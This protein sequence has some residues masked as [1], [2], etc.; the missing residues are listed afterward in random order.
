[1]EDPQLPPRQLYEIRGDPADSLDEYKRLW[2]EGTESSPPKSGP[3]RRGKQ[4]KQT[5]KTELTTPPV[6]PSVRQAREYN[7]AVLSFLSSCDSPRNI[8][9]EE[10]VFPPEPEFAY[11][12]GDDNDASASAE[13]ANTTL[14]AAHNSA[15]SLL[16]RKRPR[17]A[18]ASLAGLFVEAAFGTNASAVRGDDASEEEGTSTLLCRCAF[19]LMDCLMSSSL[20]DAGGLSSVA[21][22]VP[23]VAARSAEAAGAIFDDDDDVDG[24]DATKPGYARLTVTVDFLL[25]WVERFLEAIKADS[26]SSTAGPFPAGIHESSVGASPSELQFRFHLYKSRALSLRQPGG[27]PSPSAMKHDVKVRVARKE[28]KNVMEIYQ[29][30]LNR[31]P[32]EDL[33]GGGGAGAATVTTSK[34]EVSVAAGSVGS[35]LSDGGL[36]SSSTHAA[37]SGGKSNPH[38]ASAAVGVAATA[39]DPPPR[40]VAARLEAQNQCALS[41]KANFE[42]LKGN[43]RKALKLCAE[44]KLA[45]ERRR[46]SDGAGASGDAAVTAP[47]ASAAVATG[48]SATGSAVDMAMHHN[49][50]AL[51]HHASG[52]YHAALRY[53]AMALSCVEN[54]PSSGGASFASV[55]SAFERDGTF[56]HVPTAEILHNAA[57]CAFAA[58]NFTCAYECMARCV[59]SSPETYGGRARC[60]FRMAEGCIGIHAD[61]RRKRRREDGM[62][63]NSGLALRRDP[64]TDG[65]IINVSSAEHSRSAAAPAAELAPILGSPE[66]IVQVSADPLP[67]ALFCLQ[68]ALRLCESIPGSNRAVPDNS[69][70]REAAAVSL[71]FVYLELNDPMAA[72][73]MAGRVLNGNP[74]NS[75]DAVPGDAMFLRRRA[76]ARLYSCEALCMLNEPRRALC[77][78]VGDDHATEPA[79]A[80]GA[81]LPIVTAEAAEVLARQL[82]MLT[83]SERGESKAPKSS[84]GRGRLEDARS[85]ISVTSSG[86]AVLVGD[87]RTARDHAVRAIGER[88][89]LDASGSATA[90]YSGGAEAASNG[91]QARR[92]LLYCFLR[93]GDCEGAVKLLR[94]GR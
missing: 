93:E 5:P 3:K 1:M 78:L 61:L 36:P 13:Q 43:P 15:L 52:R 65:V 76:T 25:S 21:A 84:W 92:A 9:R 47:S 64:S 53:Y 40:W 8:D 69:N 66:D 59:G 26:A 28:L 73:S 33:R 17:E 38:P 16:A 71:A 22:S 60:W 86:C 48:T 23:S 19:L 24:A 91:A 20:G 67:R 49:N 82:A 11:L 7:C 30:K 34:D 94:A 29:H 88:G 18:A 85:A 63:D 6:E 51:I 2:D 74:G 81:A 10:S 50:L 89:G 68:R 14:A 56:L 87:L 39:D 77:V 72:L 41:L 90:Q 54:L 83:T 57:L 35:T 45:G 27:Y 62:A 58:R 80:D 31:W 44:A 75:S 42:Y 46:A 79:V 70:C 4:S 32:P 37:G 12:Y 55:S